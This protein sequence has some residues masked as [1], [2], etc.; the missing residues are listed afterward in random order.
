[1]AKACD[2]ESPGRLRWVTKHVTGV[3]GVGKFLERWKSQ[4]HSRCPGC[5]APNEDNRHVYQCPAHSTELEWHGTT[6]DIRQW[7]DLHDT[8]PAITEVILKCL[9]AWQ[10]GRI[11]PPNRG[12]DTL[13][14]AYDAQRVIGWGC[15]LEGSLAREWKTVQNTYLQMM[16]SR[17]TASIWARGLIRRLWKAAFRLWLHRNSWQHSD[18]NPQHQHDLVELDHQ[19]TTAYALGTA[20]VRPEHHHIFTISLGNRLLT[21]LF[22]KQK[23]LA[24][25]DFARAKATAHH[26]SRGAMLLPVFPRLK[27]SLLVN[28]V[29]NRGE[30]QRQSA[31]INEIMGLPCLRF[32]LNHPERRSSVRSCLLKG[33]LSM[34]KVN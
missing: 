33:T 3:C 12:R 25:F 10:A 32:Y 5:D 17:K 20:A 14:H 15:F 28:R 34:I 31:L 6:N 29:K 11:L 24:F 18:D 7:C 2:E 13:A 4:N 27:P 1:M 23:G 30:Q 19:I 21:P 16:G 9:K 26:K 8:S 22:H